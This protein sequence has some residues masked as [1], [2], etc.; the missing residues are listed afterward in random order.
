M[1]AV[2]QSAPEHGAA[3]FADSKENTITSPKQNTAIAKQKPDQKELK[4]KEQQFIA[5]D[6]LQDRYENVRPV[7]FNKDS[8]R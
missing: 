6:R 2:Q 4:Q 7:G 5:N 3:Q 8:S 1:V